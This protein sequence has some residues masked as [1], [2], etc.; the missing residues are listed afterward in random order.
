MKNS[1]LLLL[2]VSVFAGFA[3]FSAC[4]A[5]DLP[6]Q[7]PGIYR[8]IDQPEEGF[9]TRIELIQ[10]ARVSI[11]FA[12]Y[13]WANDAVGLQMLAVIREAARRGV[14]VRII[15]DGLYNR[16]PA[17]IRS[18]LLDEGI[19]ILDYNPPKFLKLSSYLHR[20]HTKLFIVDHQ[21][22]IMGSRNIE[23]SY[24]GFA[25][26]NYVDR[27][28]LVQG[29][30]PIQAATDYFDE[31]WE[32]PTSMERIR[33]LKQS[34]DDA[35]DVLDQALEELKARDYTTTELGDYTVG[36]SVA[37]ELSFYNNLPE[38]VKSTPQIAER[39]MELISKARK[40]VMIESGY[41]VIS[42]E[43]LKIIKA[44]IARGVTVRVLTNSVRSTDEPLAQAAYLSMRHRL[45]RIGIDL[46]EYN[47]DDHLHVKSYIIDSKSVIIG[48]Y[49]LDQLSRMQN[50]ETISCIDDEQIAAKVLQSMNENLKHATQLTPT[51]DAPVPSVRR[52]RQPF[53]KVIEVRVMQYLLGALLRRVI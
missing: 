48:S 4:A 15:V 1:G 46:W 23:N 35:S 21:T 52:S 2:T 26:K 34:P 3:C 30:K 49:N 36:S 7:P 20:M 47:G 44:A 37:E 16:I 27:D 50:T 24:F 11:D 17:A 8:V 6:P 32:L 51:D 25:N 22:M 53:F 14:R 40:S 39:L 12:S 13:S 38:I 45:R 31:L 33:K 42:P 10:K 19:P 43:M 5:E 29:P 18:T 9:R 28:I 41:L